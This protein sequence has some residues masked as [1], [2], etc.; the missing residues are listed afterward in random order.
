[1]THDTMGWWQPPVT[2]KTARP[3][4]LHVV[5]SAAAGLDQ[6]REWDRRQSPVWRTAFEQCVA[7]MDGKASPDEARAAFLAAAKATKNLVTE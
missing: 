7:A 4:K 1:M 5:S 6:L 2:V 3:G